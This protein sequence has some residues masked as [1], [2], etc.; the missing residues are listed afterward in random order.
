MLL[1]CPGPSYP[2]SGNRIDT[3]FSVDS[4]VFQV[5]KWNS[6]GSISH[7]I[8]SA[9][10]GQASGFVIQTQKSKTPKCSVQISCRPADSQDPTLLLTISLVQM[11]EIW[12]IGEVYRRKQGSRE[13]KLR[14]LFLPSVLTDRCSVQ[15]PNGKVLSVK[16]RRLPGSAR[17]QRED[18]VCRIRYQISVGLTEI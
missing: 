6:K 2:E 4:D 1:I 12:S 8:L 17:A 15:L 16:L 9:R 18:H 11:N 10:V 14:T 5:G 7:S 3:V 13:R